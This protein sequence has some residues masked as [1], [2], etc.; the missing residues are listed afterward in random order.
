M[1]I[2]ELTTI[3]KHIKKTSPCPGCKKLYNIQDI[4]VLASTK[5]E[6]LLEMK[7]KY[8]KKTSLSDIVATPV[9]RKKGKVDTE[10]PLINQVIRNGITDD[11]ILDTKNFLNKFDGNFKKLFF[12]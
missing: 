5:H 3:I 12:K 1:N 4:S 9:N 10:V 7:C 6:C 2:N 11:D 8:C